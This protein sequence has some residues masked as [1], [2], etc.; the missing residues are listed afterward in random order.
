M[1]KL[2]HFSILKIKHF[3]IFFALSVLAS[4]K[5]QKE[6]LTELTGKQIPID[7]SYSSIDSIQNFINPYHD[8]V[9]QILDST[10]AYAT[11][12]ITKSD[13]KFNTT[14]GNLM[15][16]IVLTETDPIFNKRTGHHIDFVLLNHGGIRSVISKGNVTARTAYEVMPFENDVV[17]VELRGETLLKMV[18][19]LIKS[20]QA[21]PVAGI[22]LILNKDNTLNTFTIAGKPLDVNRNYFVATSDYLVTGGDNM[23]FFKEALSK[24]ETDYKIRNAMIDYFSKKDTIAP[25][26]DLRYYQLQ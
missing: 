17:V 25:T 19:Y 4:C 6:H 10:L 23:N 11:S 26:V 3:V 13:G 22:Q 1:A 14:A 2:K 20:K 18:D 7:S 16:D 12:T 9:E 5:N 15:A 8:R 21:H 24:T